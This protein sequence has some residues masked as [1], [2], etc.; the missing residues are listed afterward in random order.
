MQLGEKLNLLTN[1]IIP[2]IIAYSP[3]PN[4]RGAWKKIHFDKEGGVN[5]KGGWKIFEII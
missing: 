4:C 5:K 2:L 3:V 1:I